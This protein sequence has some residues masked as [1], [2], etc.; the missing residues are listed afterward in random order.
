MD[1]VLSSNFILE[2]YNIQEISHKSPL[3]LFPSDP[4]F[5]FHSG[6]GFLNPRADAFEQT[7]YRSM[8]ENKTVSTGRHK[9]NNDRQNNFYKVTGKGPSF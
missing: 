8:E 9:A 7:Y 3:Q 6:S 5:R 1:E 2:K 4:E